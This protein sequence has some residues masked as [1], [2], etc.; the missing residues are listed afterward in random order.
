MI[1]RYVWLAEWARWTRHRCPADD[2]GGAVVYLPGHLGDFLEATP[3]L[4]RLREAWEGRR[5]VWLVGSWGAALARRFGAYCDEVAVFSPA[6]PNLSRGQQPQGAWEQWRLLQRLSKAGV[7]ALVATRIEDAVTRF[8]ANMLRPGIWTGLGDRR[9]PRVAR[10]VATS[11]VPYDPRKPEAEALADLLVPLGI[12]SRGVGTAFWVE[13]DGDAGRAEEFLRAEAVAVDRPLVLV[14]AGSG[15]EGKNWGG[16]HF[17]EVAF[18]MEKSGAQ[19]AWIGTEDEKALK[20]AGAAGRDWFG[21]LDIGTLASVMKRAALWIGNDSG[22]LHLAAA[23]GCK[24][25]SLWGPTDPEKWAPL[26][27]GNHVVRKVVAR[28]PGCVYWDWRQHCLKAAHECMDAISPEEVSVLAREI[29]AM[30]RT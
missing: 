10:E 30:K 1:G 5:I 19:V 22:P 4:R 11:L 14:S 20:P 16:R 9:P 2:G 6:L 8:L 15:W 25:L 28:C 18:A 13:E 21:R 26:G 3:M 29:L 17:A 27:E 12:S 24:T 23:V 7:R